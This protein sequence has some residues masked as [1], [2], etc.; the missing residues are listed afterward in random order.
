MVPNRP[1]SARAPD[2]PVRI[3]PMPTP[4][5]RHPSPLNPYTDSYLPY[6]PKRGWP[7]TIPNTDYT[8]YLSGM[9][10]LNLPAT[11]GHRHPGDWHSIST[12]WSP[13]YLD[14]Y[15]HPA[16][17]K[18]WGPDGDIPGTPIHPRLRD[19]RNALARLGHPAAANSTPVLAATVPQAIIDL[20]W[21]Q[22]RHG[23]PAIDRH[24]VARWTG[25]D[26]E[27]PELC[28][29]AREIETII[30]DPLQHGRWRHW[31]LH[32]LQ[33]PD[34]IELPSPPPARPTRPP[35]DVVIRAS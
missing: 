24:T 14:V 13:T 4:G 7:L 32:H 19:A 31:R 28:M 5:T 9:T 6:D 30:D 25:R 17:A 22:L 8:A 21:D 2:I 29:L 35:I 12:W 10:A 20:A 15:D 34:R 23:R 16:T 18:L 11:H 1:A 3:R 26:D 33:G 27:D